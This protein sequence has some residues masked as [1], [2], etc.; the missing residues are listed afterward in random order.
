MLYLMEEYTAI[1]ARIAR[2]LAGAEEAAGTDWA[3]APYYPFATALI[4]VSAYIGRLL[5]SE[6]GILEMIQKGKGAASGGAIARGRGGV[7]TRHIADMRRRRWGL[8]RS[9]TELDR[10]FVTMAELLDRTF[11]ERGATYLE[12]PGAWAEAQAVLERAIKGED[13]RS[14]RGADLDVAALRARLGLSPLMDSAA[15]LVRRRL[16]RTDGRAGRRRRVAND[17]WGSS[18]PDSPSTASLRGSGTGMTDGGD[19]IVVSA[20]EDLFRDDLFAPLGDS[21]SISDQSSGNE[22]WVSNA[23]MRRARSGRSRRSVVTHRHPP[24]LG[25]ARRTS[26]SAGGG[27]RAR[28][29]DTGARNG[30]RVVQ[31]SRTLRK[32]AGKVLVLRALSM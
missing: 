20:G 6:G 30:G 3:S 23:A 27:L 12:F 17:S 21:L 16:A 32:G 26:A 25:A 29:M 14:L 5:G 11:L 10:L 18:S 2:R 8:A 28:R 4:N 19:W 22:N 13:P 15:G 9:R 7:G 31:S 24:V 1:G